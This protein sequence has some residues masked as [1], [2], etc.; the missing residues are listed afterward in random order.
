MAG[1][2]W[3][4]RDERA[5]TTLRSAGATP[6]QARIIVE[7][8][9][10]SRHAAKRV[11]VQNERDMRRV[12]GTNRLVEGQYATVA[13]P[14]QGFHRPYRVVGSTH[15]GASQTVPDSRLAATAVANE[16]NN[17]RKALETAIALSVMA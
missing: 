10:K 1:Q 12:T 7:N 13:V 9:R 6:E 5:Y 14:Q 8:Q 15:I 11:V 4:E 3:G 2:R 16:S 17:R